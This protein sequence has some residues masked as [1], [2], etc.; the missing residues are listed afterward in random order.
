M[1]DFA[2]RAMGYVRLQARRF[3]IPRSWLITFSLLI[4]LPSIVLVYAYSQ[5]TAS[6]L[7][8]EVSN[9]MQ[10]TV[11][12][13]GNNLS[14]RLGHIRDISNAASINP[15]LHQFLKEDGIPSIEWQLEILKE[16]RYFVETIQ[17]NTDVFRLRL[18]VKN[19]TMLSEE[20]YN[21]FS[22]DSL[23][24]WPYYGEVLSANGAIVWTDIYKQDYI[25]SGEAYI[26][27]SA[28][29]LH[30]SEQFGEVG[31]V[32]VI[33]VSEE[34]VT[35]I[36]SDID[37]T[38]PGN[39]F[40][41]D[42]DGAVV[43]HADKSR[44]GTP[45]EEKVRLAIQQGQEGKV[46]IE[47][48]N[49][50]EYAMYSTI[51]PTGWKVVVQVPAADISEKIKL[52]KTAGFATLAG[53]FALFLLLVFALLALIVRSMNRR[54][55]QVIRVIRTEGIERLDEP[56]SM[57]EGNFMMLERSVDMLMRRMRS[58]MEQTYKAQVLER[59]AQLR[60]LQAQINPHFLYNTLDTINWI[61]IGHGKHDISEMIDALAKY[62]RLSLNKGRDVMSVADELNLARVYL[63]IQ[64]SRFLNSFEYRI[65]PETDLLDYTVPKLTL[66]PI[67]ENALLHGI[68][69]MKNKF[70]TILIRAYRE[71]NEL[72][73]EVSDNGIGMEEEHAQRLLVEPQTMARA[74]GSGSS[75]GLY[76]VNERI[77]LFAGEAS[78]LRI[79]SRL[80]E[81]T[82]V[83]VHIRLDLIA[84]PASPPFGS[85]E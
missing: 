59:E 63:D 48:N 45:L 44:I 2:R 36:L 34:L 28:R 56:Q 8:E 7:E 76:N 54:L 14:Y 41:V 38:K 18:F 61:A 85:N 62:F 50:Y 4:V 40:I 52:K 78:G 24:S 83:T 26:M 60:A 1:I 25:G 49:K 82:S 64:K 43:A 6:I 32:L 69:K 10:Q 11:K 71:G 53:V 51:Q 21:F 31:A 79:T 65:E 68:H 42:R 66:Q 9:S 84:R 30:D 20:R 19:T 70:G 23:K 17:T 74:E 72:I 57:P 47:L 12:Q 55:Q 27:S 67:V 75:Y 15:M 3:G 5:R 22:L 58:L 13:A 46:K 73:L 81:G 77:K 80:G 29:M 37:L 39:V 16:L 33:D 35:D